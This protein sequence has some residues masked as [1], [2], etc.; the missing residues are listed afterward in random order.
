MEN[1]KMTRAEKERIVETFDRCL[2]DEMA[3]HPKLTRH[4]AVAS[5]A[6]KLPGL[7]QR[8]LEAT[9]KGYRQ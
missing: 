6:K 2:R 7:Q 5:L 9:H 4:E 8:Y 1:E 3:E